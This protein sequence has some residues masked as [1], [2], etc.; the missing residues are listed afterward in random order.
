MGRNVLDKNRR[1]RESTKKRIVAVLEGV[2]LLVFTA[3]CLFPV[4]WIVLSSFKSHIDAIIIPPVWLFRPLLSNYLQ[5]ISGKFARYFMSSLIVAT[6]ST[7]IVLLVGIPAGYA[8]AKFP[9]KRKKD[10][11]FWILTTRMAPP[12]VILLPYYLAFI[13]FHLLDTHVA[14]ILMHLTINL[15]LAVWIMKGFFQEIP[16][17]LEDAALVDG[18]GYLGAFIRVML[19]LCR[20]GIV[21]TGILCFIFSWNELLFA[22]TIG[23][24]NVK[25]LPPSVYDFVTYREV[26]WPQLCA[27]ATVI[28]IPVMVFVFIVQ[29]HLIRGMTMGAFK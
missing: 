25:T 7:F 1:S 5:I 19:P 15:S 6:T 26:L 11:L 4:L 10:L 28:V 14:I 3:V 20:P 22:I 17:G 18:C 23:A 12:I 24:Q 8:F 29:K 16:S 2:V 27:A 21:A 9:I 13:K